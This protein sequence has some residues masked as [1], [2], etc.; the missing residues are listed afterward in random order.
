LELLKSNEVLNKPEPIA[1]AAAGLLHH[2][3]LTADEWGKIL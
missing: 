2:L 1:A 3:N